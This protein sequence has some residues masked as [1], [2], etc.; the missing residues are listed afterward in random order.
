MVA[1]FGV[2]GV[3]GWPGRAPILALALGLMLRLGLAGDRICIR[4]ELGFWLADNRDAG[5]G[6]LGC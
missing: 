5:V 6:V 4:A 2:I 3:P 1:M